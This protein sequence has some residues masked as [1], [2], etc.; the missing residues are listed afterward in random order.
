ME[1]LGTF[2]VTEVMVN[3]AIIAESLLRKASLEPLLPTLEALE[4]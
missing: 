4:S 1:A 2:E 3:L